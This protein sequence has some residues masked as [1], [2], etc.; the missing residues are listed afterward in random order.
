[1]EAGRERSKVGEKP[2]NS[3][4]KVEEPVYGSEIVFQAILIK[5]W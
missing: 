2:S 4:K 3:A 1:M 5:I